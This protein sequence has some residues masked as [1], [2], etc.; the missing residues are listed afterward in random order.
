MNIKDDYTEMH[1]SFSN[2]ETAYIPVN[3]WCVPKERDEL[4]VSIPADC[5]EYFETLDKF[6]IE[7]ED[8]AWQN[9]FN[10]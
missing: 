5:I 8:E 10:A 1:I 6:I 9:M 3:S 7:K 2:G 4:M